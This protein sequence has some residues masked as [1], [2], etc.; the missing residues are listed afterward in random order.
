MTKPLTALMIFFCS[1]TLW[2]QL[3]IDTLRVYSPSMQREISNLVLLPADYSPDT[4]SYPLVFLL[5]GAYEN[6]TYWIQN[7]PELPSLINHYQ[8]VV[9]C[10]DGGQTGWYLDSPQLSE[11][12]Y[13]SYLN[14]EL[15]KI[16]ENSYHTGG[17]PGQRGITGLSMG[18]HGALL[19][20]LK[21]PEI[22]GYAGSM[23]G[24]LDLR[25]FPGNW[26]L[27]LLLGPLESNKGIWE[28]AS[29]VTYADKAS[30]DIPRI[31]MDCG[32]SDFFLEVN[33]NF[34]NILDQLGKPH[35]YIERKGGHEISYWRKSLP[36]H[37]QYLGKAFSGDLRALGKVTVATP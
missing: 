8:F 36:Q 3:R 17:D 13:E 10:P 6:F 28:R 37:F 34:H 32:T 25:P 27:K 26:N 9:V 7:Y 31:Y 16:V 35:Y 4:K 24:G 19:N 23:S 1:T 2:A 12:Q 22:W 15:L 33:R 20:A 11:N 29:V 18:G 14:S 21:H 5:H 30:E